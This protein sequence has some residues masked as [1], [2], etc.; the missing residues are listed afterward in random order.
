MKSYLTIVAS[1]IRE[2]DGE[3]RKIKWIDLLDLS[4]SIY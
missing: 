2:K 4:R 3:L 1:A